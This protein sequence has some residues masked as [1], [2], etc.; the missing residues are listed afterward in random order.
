MWRGIVGTGLCVQYWDPEKALGFFHEFSGWLMFLVSMG[1]LYLVHIL[2]SPCRTGKGA[3]TMRKRSLL[4]SPSP[5][6]SSEPRCCTAAAT[7]DHV[8]PQHPPWIRCRRHSV[9]GWEPTSPWRRETLDVLGTGFFLNPDLHAYCFDRSIR[10]L[11]GLFIGYFPTQRT[12]QSIHSPQHCLPA[13]VGRSSRPAVTNVTD[14][15]GKTSQCG[16]TTSSST[17]LRGAEVLYWYQSHGRAIAN[18]YK[19]KLYMLTDSI[20]YNRSDA[21]PGADRDAGAVG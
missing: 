3:R 20:R 15:Q 12:G 2:M 6:S 9:P 13:R 8:P 17:V 14:T 4:D 10:D 1:C 16:R 21:A 19:A 18:D 7:R 11:S 5:C